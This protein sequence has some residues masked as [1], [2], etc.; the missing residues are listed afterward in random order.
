MRVELVQIAA[1]LP[2]NIALPRVTLA[3][4][5]FVEEVQRLIRKR[6]ST[7]STLEATC[8]RIRPR[9]GGRLAPRVRIGI[10]AAVIVVA[11]TGGELATQVVSQQRL[12]RRHFDQ[13]RQRE[14]ARC[15]ACIV[16]TVAVRLLLDGNQGDR[17]CNG[18]VSPTNIPKENTDSRVILSL[19][20]SLS[21][22]HARDAFGAR[23][24]VRLSEV[25]TRDF[26]RTIVNQLNM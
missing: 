11:G 6:D 23:L 3:V 22:S 20:L 8:A 16:H 9:R 12:E 19:F 5:T 4:T 17:R 25:E 24:I 14:I 1:L 2:A 21:P 10:P 18:F 13:G 26:E 7:V 15:R